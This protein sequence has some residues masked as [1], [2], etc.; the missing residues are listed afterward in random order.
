MVHK[1]LRYFGRAPCHESSTHP[2]RMVH[3]SNAIFHRK[4]WAWKMRS[5]TTAEVFPTQ[6]GVQ[7]CRHVKKNVYFCSQRLKG[8]DVV[9]KT[10]GF[11]P[12]VTVF[13]L[14]QKPQPSVPV[15]IVPIV[16]LKISDLGARTNTWGSTTT[17][18]QR[19][20]RLINQFPTQPTTVKGR[21]KQ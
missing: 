10:S 19:T 8:K 4:P 14:R 20:I 9:G 18:L 21:P 11:P 3:Q 1:T 12:L 17:T 15:P 13:S 6:T 5:N 7:I 16:P 2:I